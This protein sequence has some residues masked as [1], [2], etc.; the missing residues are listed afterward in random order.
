MRCTDTGRGRLDLNTCLLSMVG[1]AAFLR[2]R[3]LPVV[4]A[5]VLATSCA[6]GP[7]PLSQST[8][9][10]LSQNGTA[11]SESSIEKYLRLAHE[12]VSF[13]SSPDKD[14]V[15]FGQSICALYV[16]GMNQTQVSLELIKNQTANQSSDDLGYI[17]GIAVGTFCPQYA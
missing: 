14:L 9:A 11:S 6:S 13:K 12:Q 7:K 5:A 17:Q 8:S 10:P 15:E 1:F 3:F 4:V 16:G 2:K